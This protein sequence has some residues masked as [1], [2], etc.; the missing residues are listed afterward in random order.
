MA[1]RT[2][3]IVRGV[4]RRLRRKQINTVSCTLYVDR[5]QSSLRLSAVS[6]Y[7]V[8]RKRAAGN[9]LEFVK[10]EAGTN[11]PLPERL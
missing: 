2:K 6:S 4:L 5:P 7:G 10:V 3:G 11:T 8:H 9:G 1:F